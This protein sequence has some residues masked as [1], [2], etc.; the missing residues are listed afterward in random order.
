RPLEL[1]AQLL[2]EA[3][4]Q[5]PERRSAGQRQRLPRPEGGDGGERRGFARLRRPVLEVELAAGLLQHHYTLHGSGPAGSR[6][7]A[8]SRVG[9]GA[10]PSP[11]VFGAIR[12]AVGTVSRSRA[13]HVPALG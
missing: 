5:G 4:E 3:E 2:L 12:M 8:P 6:P 11:A 9:P 13:R 7:A 10:P 1:V